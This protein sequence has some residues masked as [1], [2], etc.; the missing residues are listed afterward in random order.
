M[1]RSSDRG[2]SL[3]ELLLSV[4]ILMVVLSGLLL[5]FTNCIILNETSRDISIATS[6]AQYILEEVRDTPF[7][8][9]DTEITV[10]GKWNWDT[11]EIISEGLTP[12]RDEAIYT[13]TSGASLDPLLVI[14]SVVWKNRKGALQT[15]ELYTQ[16]TDY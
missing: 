10:N 8:D 11:N 4:L 3:P 6:H 5:L 15:Q 2:F 13:Y 7:A 16:V 1:M 9:L 12:L 14:A